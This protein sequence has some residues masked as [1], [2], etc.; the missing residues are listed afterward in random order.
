MKL[1]WVH[2]DCLNTAWFAAADGPAVFVF[3]D[4]QLAAEAWGL[5]RI[6]FVYECLLE[7]PGVEIWR[8]PAVE[9]LAELVAT[10]GLEAVVTVRTV[11][12]WL[13]GQA[14]ELTARGVRVEWVEPEPL[15]TLRGRV[16]LGRFS[17]YWRKAEGA[18]LG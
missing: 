16:D 15:V 10:R 11:D 14:A 9:T 6:G 5:K 17:R 3:D 8:G 7:M 2:G 18:L 13:L 1:H 12:P 4:R